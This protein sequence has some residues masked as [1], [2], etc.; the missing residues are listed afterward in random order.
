[1]DEQRDKKL[2]AKNIRTALILA[3]V[4]LAFLLGMVLRR[5]A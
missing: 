1:M 2:R 3:S 5:L 4:A